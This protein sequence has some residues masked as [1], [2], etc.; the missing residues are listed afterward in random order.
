MFNAWGLL[1][2]IALYL[3]LLFL[4]AYYAERRQQAGRSVVANPYV[5][6]LSLAV[7]C[8]SWTFYGSVGKAATSGLSFL[9]IYLGPTLMAALWLV[10]LKKMV[11]IAKENRITTLSDF[12]GSRYGNSL[13]LSALVAVV[14]L[15]GITP[16]LGLQM[17]AIMS[18]FAILAGQKSSQ[19]AGWFIALVLGLFAVVF[20]ARRLD[21]SR[22]NQGLVLAI[23][24]ESVVKLVAFLAV[25]FYVTYGLFGGF[26]DLVERVREAELQH[27]LALGEGSR[28]G[29]AEWTA[30]LALSMMAILFLPRQ[31]HM[32]VVELTDPEH[33]KKAMW[34][35]PLYL[36]LINIFVLPVAFGGLLLTGSSQGAD[37][38]VLS[39][40][41]SQGQNHLALLVFI[42]GF[43]AATGMIIVESLAISTMVMNSIVMP[44]IY[45][46]HHTKGFFAMIATIKRLLILGIVFLGYVFAVSVGE[47]Y[48]LVDMGLKSF[49]AVSILAP[50]VLLGMYWRRG[51]RNGAIAGMLA[52][53]AVWL[54]TLLLP[55]L[56]RARVIEPSGL[57]GWLM[58]SRFLHPHALFGLTGLDR[59]SHSL[60]WGLMFNVVLY[61][62]VSLLSRQSEVERQQALVFVEAYQPAS[63]EAGFSLQHIE[64]T[65]AQYLGPWEARQVLE[66]F[67]RS[68][69][70]KAQEMGPRELSQ[71]REEARRVLSGSLGSPIATLI[72]EHRLM[73]QQRGELLSSIKQMTDTLRLS[74]QELEEANR[75]LALLKEFSENIIESLPL[76]V[77]TTDEQLKVGYWNKA[78]ETITGVSKEDALG[79]EIELL[80]KCLEP[81][82][83][84]SP[85]PREGELT[86]RRKEGPSLVLKGHLSKLRGAQKGYVLVLEDITEKERIQEE[87]MRTSKHASLGRLAAGVSHEIGN[88]LASISSLLQELMAE[89]QPPQN[90][91]VLRTLSHHVERIAR[92]VRSLGDF[93]RLSPRQRVPTRLEETLQNTLNLIRY[94]K[95]FRRIS[96]HTHIQKGLPALRLD[97]DQMQQ[98]FLNLLLNARDAM[99]Q[100]GEL[101]ID[102]R[103]EDSWVVASFRD[104]GEGI[105]QELRDKI[106]DPFFSTKGPHRGTGL[107]LSICYSIVKD[108]G[109]HIE[110]SSN[111]GRG[112]CFVI[113]LPLGG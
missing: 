52:A 69:G 77:A 93:A 9:T 108:H 90:Q 32:A 105:P 56:L 10:V 31:F 73:P 75:Q 44:A 68:K 107:G 113:K 83:F 45:R 70:L 40:P 42:G 46:F 25:G 2:V 100:G 16:Y 5:Y 36:V 82:I 86:C 55:A 57:L 48:S 109:G 74:R 6:S 76:G 28:V 35:F 47:F 22:G 65:L 78:M 81:E 51:H 20:G 72:L 8:T 7:Y 71:L 49:E 54:Y 3:G 38:F 61:V 37:S 106:F 103:Q 53:L 24:L 23:A 14:A 21:I 88:P 79:E 97:P 62:G 101:Y 64:E 95:Q 80:L 43:A 15:V 96:L 102:I 85:N 89:Q 26:G 18:T 58:D 17:K 4:V 50:A 30:L 66:G 94:D 63:P 111:Q 33:L 39:I 84:A 34:L 1:F 59:W 87:L 104:T 112:S 13:T 67:L 11:T 110:V 91:E 29:Y 19:A 41:L 12:I 27:L 99:P 60:L 98:V 92:I